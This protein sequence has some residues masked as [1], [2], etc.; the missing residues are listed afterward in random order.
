MA[1][2]ATGGV[3]HPTG[4]PLY[5]LLARAFQFLPVSSLAFRTNLLSAFTTVLAAGLVYALVASSSADSRETPDWPAGLA[6]GFAFGLAP[7]LWSQAVITEVYGLQVF[8][9]T[10]I[11][12]LYTRPAAVLPSTQARLDCWRGLILGLGM[13]NHLTTLL[14]VPAAFVLGSVRCPRPADGTA[15]PRRLY[16]VNLMLD[17]GALLRQLGMFG[18][19][20]C[21]YLVIPIRA[22]ANPPVNWGNAVTPARLWWLL[23]GQ[24]Y[25]SHYLQ[26]NLTESVDRIQSVASLL[27]Q[28]F[29]LPGVILGFVGLIIFG[30]NSRLYIL[31]VWTAIVFT[32]FAVVYGSYD[33]YVYLM[34]MFLSFSIWIGLSLPGLVN[35]ISA[36]FSILRFGLCLLI[37]G[38]FMSR[39]FSYFSVVDASHDA[40][41]VDFG[42][43][44]LATLPEHA[45]V[46]AQGDEAVFALWYFHFALGQRPDLAVM[47]SD[48]LHFDW[49]GETLRSTYPSLLVPG[50]FPWPETIAAANPSRPACYIAYADQTEIQCAEPLTSP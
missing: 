50:P 31:T 28:Q 20:L 39:S 16:P 10:L 30:R 11:L 32:V 26:F 9:V 3:A 2:A 29:G 42:R 12:Y 46:F 14:L 45:L 44:A 18:A 43:E 34:P 47:A 5:L 37:M 22:A 40:R 49:Y 38:Y 23:S 36:R 21:L 24:L 48:L 15:S 19:G 33:S 13:G 7:L 27:L 25:Q 41:A 35:Q 17:R 4:Y 8:L 6:A 1:A